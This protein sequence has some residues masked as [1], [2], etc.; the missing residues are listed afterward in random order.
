[1][2]RSTNNRTHGGS[3]W[4]RPRGTGRRFQKMIVHS[5]EVLR[6]VVGHAA[7]RCAAFAV[8][9]APPPFSRRTRTRSPSTTVPYAPT[10][11][12]TEVPGHVTFGRWT[13]RINDASEGAVMGYEEPE[14]TAGW[15][16]LLVAW[17]VWTALNHFVAKAKG[18]NVVN[19][20]AGSI[21]LSPVLTYL[22]IAAVPGRRFYEAISEVRGDSRAIQHGLRAVETKVDDAKRTGDTLT[23]LDE[24]L[25]LGRITPDEHSTRSRAVIV[26]GPP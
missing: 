17:G 13:S 15:V 7:G 24:D 4:N 10:L 22:Y 5:G 9:A 19:V 3:F 23:G 2:A 8:C 6:D 12:W 11:C 1:M 20:L 14:P 18:H 16:W 25:R 21:F 26:G